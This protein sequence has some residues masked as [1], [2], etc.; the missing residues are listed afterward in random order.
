MPKD[1]QFE[2]SGNVRASQHAIDQFILRSGTQRGREKIGPKLEKML[3]RS[4]EVFK[5]NATISLLNNNGKEARYFHR[6]SWVLVVVDGVITTVY[7]PSMKDFKG[8]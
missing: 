3:S 1:L 2:I 7:Q 8:F 6:A 4:R 5:K